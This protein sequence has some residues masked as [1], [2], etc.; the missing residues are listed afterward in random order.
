[1]GYWHPRR[2]VRMFTRARRRDW[3]NLGG[4]A[5]ATAVITAIFVAVPAAIIWFMGS[6]VPWDI[7]GYYVACVI[8][9]FALGV[10]VD[11]L[12]FRRL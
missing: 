1:M 8:G 4:L 5:F 3:A 7:Y 9:L 2:I 10:I 12:W 11:W 6:T